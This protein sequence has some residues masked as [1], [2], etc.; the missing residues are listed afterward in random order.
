M[1]K[2]IEFIKNIISNS[3]NKTEI[4]SKLGLKNNGGN[5]NT[6]SSF[7]NINNINISHF[8]PMVSTKPDR[9]RTLTYLSLEDLLVLNPTIIVGTSRLKEKLYKSGLKKRYCELCNQ[10]EK[11]KGKK[12]SLILDH[13]NGNR[14]DNRIENLRIVCPNCNATLETHCRG[15][16]LNKKYDPKNK[17]CENAECDIMIR[18]RNKYCSKCYHKLRRGKSKAKEVKPRK[19]Y[20]H[21]PLNNFNNRKV[22]RPPYI[23]LIKEISEFGYKATGRKY[24]VSDNSIRKWEK[25]YNKYKN[26]S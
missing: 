1:W 5:F 15:M 8:T 6:L 21:N 3:S 22:K 18:K 4:L 23:I 17:K 26:I 25:F 7:I 16:N 10:D 9:K 20:V 2:N 11:W 14:F 12:M 24:G 19:T 13:I